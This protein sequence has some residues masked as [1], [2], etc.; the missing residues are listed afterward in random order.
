VYNEIFFSNVLKL[1]QQREM[2]KQDLGRL[3]GVSVSFLSD[4]TNGKANPSLDTLE[5]IANAF[6]LPLE[7]LLSEHDLDQIDAER[8]RPRSKGRA[9]KLR[10]GL[11]RVS[12]ELP[13]TFAAKVRRWNAFYK[14]RDRKG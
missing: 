3:S 6:D 9:F 11:E 1:L 13:P 2:S 14:G 5:K 12:A 7:W 4:L 8:L 10:P